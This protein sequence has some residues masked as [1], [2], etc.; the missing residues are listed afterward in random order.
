MDMRRI[1]EEVFTLTLYPGIGTNA[2]AEHKILI[3]NG[4]KFLLTMRDEREEVFTLS[5]E[6]FTLS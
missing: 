1:W 3:M 5:Q 6:V 4:R 2:G